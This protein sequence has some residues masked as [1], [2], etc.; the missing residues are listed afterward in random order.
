M[1][2]GSYSGP[3][4]AAAGVFQE[5]GIPYISA[6]GVHP[7]I[8]RAGDYV[9]STSFVG[10]V[11]GRAG[12]KLVGENVGAKRVSIISINNDFGQSLVAGFKEAA[13]QFGIEIV[14][15]YYYGM[16]DRQFGSIVAGIRRDAPDAIY[17]TGY[18]FTGGPLVSQL[19]SAGVTATIVGTEGFDSQNFIDIAKQAA[20]GVIITTS[21]DRGT[22]N[23]VM[24][25]FI[26]DFEKK[27]GFPADMVAATT[28][29]AVLVAAD[30]ITRAGSVDHAAIRDALAAT[31]DL[32]V[33]TGV[34]TFNS[35]GEIYHEIGAQIVKDGAFTHY[36]TIDDPVLLA[37]PTE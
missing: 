1:V 19:R 3:T 33:S 30:A 8:T 36:A 26:D 15:E 4:R 29:T 35:L 18:F 13:A 27:A 7:D 6:Y 34:L 23:P 22:E 12:A 21:L 28:H 20:E 9:F 25:A 17:A 16:A 11:Q 2:S 14:N 37:P 5:N 10:E 32:Q 31:K 24:R